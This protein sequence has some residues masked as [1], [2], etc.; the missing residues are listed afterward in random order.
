M[1]F[2]RYLI[3]QLSNEE[4][5]FE[6]GRLG[7]NATDRQLFEDPTT[8]PQLSSTA[9]FRRCGKPVELEWALVS[10]TRTDL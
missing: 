1:S 7:P 8:P 10:V 5:F 9:G 2:L 6:K 4:M 3:H